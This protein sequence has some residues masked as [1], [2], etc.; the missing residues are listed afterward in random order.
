VKRMPYHTP[1]TVGCPSE[2]WLLCTAE[3]TF[4]VPECDEVVPECDEVVPEC[5]EVGRM[6]ASYE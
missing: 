2:K 4:G 5:D 6:R 1:N 3:S